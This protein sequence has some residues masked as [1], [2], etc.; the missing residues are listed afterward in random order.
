MDLEDLPVE[1][2]LWVLAMLVLF[3]IECR[4]RRSGSKAGRKKYKSDPVP[5]A[6]FGDDD[7]HLN[8]DQEAI[9]IASC[10]DPCMFEYDCDDYDID[11]D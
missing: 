8:N 1:V 6:S 3:V 11:V 9:H 4:R 10:M 7:V 5:V 2:C